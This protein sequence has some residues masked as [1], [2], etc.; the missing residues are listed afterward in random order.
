MGY[1]I[2]KKSLRHTFYTHTL[3]RSRYKKE[4]SLVESYKF[5]FFLVRVIN[6]LFNL[7][8]L[9]LRRPLPRSQPK[10]SSLWRRISKKIMKKCLFLLC[11]CLHLF[12]FCSFFFWYLKNVLVACC[13]LYVSV[14]FGVGN[15][16]IDWNWFCYKDALLVVS[17][18][19]KQKLIRYTNSYYIC[20]RLW[21]VCD[22]L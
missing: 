4:S 14:L 16:L 12:A 2:F 19:F 10:F 20:D 18:F 3:L 8:L 21:S 17:V 7:K 5:F 6:I 13:C 1:I 22:R 11:F 15:S 9:R